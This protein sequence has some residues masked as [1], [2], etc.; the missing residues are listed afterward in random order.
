M[1]SFILSVAFIFLTT[2]SFSQ[3][4]LIETHQNPS[5][6]GDCNGIIAITPNN[7][8]GAVS[9]TWNP[10]GSTGSTI[11]G[12]CAGT[13]TVLA[14]DAASNTASLSITLTDPPV[15]TSSISASG[16]VS[17]FGGNNGYATVTPSGPATTYQWSNGSNVPTVSNLL[18]GVYS[19]TL[20][21]SFG[22][23]TTSTVAIIQPTQLTSTS[24]HLN[25][26]C[27]GI[28]NGSISISVSGGTAP[29]TYASSLGT[30]T[31]S[32]T[33]V[34]SGAYTYTITDNA[35]CIS[36]QY[37]VVSQ[38][39]QLNI[40]STITDASCGACN[41]SI[42]GTA[43][44]GNPPYLYTW[45]PTGPPGTMYPNLCAGS[46]TLQITDAN[47][48]VKSN[49]FVV[50]AIGSG[51]LSGVSPSFSITNETCL[52]S[53]DGSVDL[54]L[55][56]SNP[57]PFTYQWDNGPTSEDLYNV[58]SGNYQVTVFDAGMACL[59]TTA[60]VSATGINCGSISG[61]V[62]IDNNTDC[63]KNSGDVDF[64]GALVIA[65]PGN[66][67]G[68]A[69]AMG[70]YTINNLVY[71]TYSVSLNVST[72]YVPSCT[73]ALNKTINSGSPAAINTDFSAGF[74]SAVQPDM[75]VSGSSSNIAPGF[76]GSTYY[77]LSNLN[78]VNGTGLFKATLPPGFVST[79]QTVTPSTYTVSGDTVIWNFSNITYSGG[80]AYFYLQ[81][82]TPLS[83]PLGSIFNTCMYTEPNVPDFNPANNTYCH[84]CTVTGSYDPNDKTVSPVGSTA[85]G[86]IPF[87]TTDLTYLIR[88]QNTGNGPAVNIVVKDTVS[89]NVDIS[90]FEMLSA[91]HNYQLD[92]LDGNVL[93]WKF[94]NIMLADSG[95]NEPA[96]HGYI[97]YRIKRNPVYT[98]GLEIKNTAYIYFDFNAPVVTNT[99]LNTIEYITGI[100]NSAVN[101]NEWN[102]YPNPNSGTLYLSNPSG[103]KEQSLVT[104]INSIGQTVHEESMNSNYKT[105]DLNK[106]N[107]GV[108]FVKVTS[109]SK[110]IIKRIVLN[111]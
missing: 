14:E 91:S 31:P 21:N 55:S 26:S 5:C 24:T 84:Q 4:S 22:C 33:N 9:Y 10:L 71:G 58:S 54:S 20:T 108:Y 2:L 18:A 67:Y 44:G 62:F 19:V 78:N 96:S 104:V 109:D 73:T 6:N 51:S 65:N 28:C 75:N 111:K 48:C 36:M 76:V 100:K 90:T 103:L 85:A 27:F 41:G 95:S 93:R 43:F 63:I 86:Y 37:V 39:S 52:G 68:Y 45:A 80:P 8:V 106:L 23:T 88:F 87:V 79:L 40:T 16:N 56:G 34:C 1:K 30:T 72:I 98:P 89:P 92:I 47:G 46:Y 57:G 13:Y 11:N 77:Y 66:R 7:M 12:L 99:A 17:C 107:N 94:N 82:V 38:T 32:L 35:G 25:A 3:L 61:N 70:N 83:T 81:F 59:I 15:F 110:S 60:S 101:E 97:Q 53:G 29:Y 69:D 102:A 42:I 49:S 50:N 74:N 64:Q 105:L